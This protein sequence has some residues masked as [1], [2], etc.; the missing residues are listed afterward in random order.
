VCASEASLK[1]VELSWCEASAM[2]LLF[3]ALAITSFS[4]FIID[5]NSIDLPMLGWGAFA[6]YATVLGAIC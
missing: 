5:R 6:V 3:D 2:S 1:L 4:I